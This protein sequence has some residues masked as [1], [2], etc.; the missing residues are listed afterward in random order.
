MNN[1]KFIK[2]LSIGNKIVA[3]VLFVSVTV[4]SAGFGFIA[5]WDINRLKNE[6]QSKLILDAKLI[7]DYCVV[8]L[9]FEDKR[10]AREALSRLKLVESV[11]EGF[12][13]DGA[14]SLFAVYP[15]TLKPAS[16]PETLNHEG[17]AFKDG[18][19]YINEPV[20]FQGM[21]LGKLVVQANSKSLESRKRNLALTIMGLLSILILISYLLAVRMQKIISSPIVEL[22]NHFDRIAATKDY[23]AR[24]RRRHN[25]ETGN[26]YDG[27]NELLGTIDAQNRERKKLIDDLSHSRSML[28]TILD[29]IPQSIFWK[30]KNSVYLGCNR[31]FADSAGIG[32]PDLIA[33]KTDQDLPWK[34]EAERYRADD[35]EVMTNGTARYHII[36]PLFRADGKEIWA[37]T[38]KIPLTGSDGRVN[39]VLGVLEDITDRKRAEEEL[40]QSEQR[41]K[42]LL[43][44]ITDYTYSV[45]IQNERPVKTVHGTGCVKVTGFKPADYTAEDKL[46]LQ[47]V[48]PDDRK[49]VEHYADP[50]YGG[51]EIPPLEHR[52]IHKNGPVIWVRNT[53]VLKHD[54]NGK[55]IGYDGL[56]SDITGR[57]LAEEEIR[58]LNAE[59]EDR[60]TQRTAQLETAN[61]ELEAF[62]YSVSHDLRAP[63]RHASGYVDLLLKRFKSDLPEKGRHYLNSI[64]DSVHQMGMLIDDL[65]QFSR[66][67]RT[68]MRQAQTDM[69]GIVHE[70]MES[71][72]QDNPLRA[73]EWIAG[74]LPSVFCDEAML[75]LVW[76]NLLSN[77][78]K[79]TRTREKATIEIGAH[80]EDKEFV[81][82]ARDNGVGFDMRYAQKLFGVFQRLH[83]MEEFEGTGIGLANVRR[84][85]S[86]HEGRTWAQAEPDKGATLY[87]SLPKFKKE[88]P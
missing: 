25:D 30:D 18:H 81:F 88:T 34:R 39:A 11:D 22:K 26:L 10:Q 50:L 59:L 14:G 56:I 75:K 38:A 62:S 12:L 78:V 86:R 67:G 80:E 45:E 4:I 52:I 84:I 42:Q 32:H 44:S 48:H 55:V 64:A 16:V 23:S 87:F 79:F 13:F 85:I 74:R 61:K 49:T 40:R 1:L 19:F 82:F 77:A 33:G 2:D 36:E 70:V 41:Y 83:S 29:T 54:A 5:T 6:I 65:L 68:E 72:R 73:I 66:T 76:M 28:N 31:T 17:A 20:Y 3:I 8:P 24:V 53:Y 9:T 57:K 7:G 69:N 47:M 60:V 51:K 58:R 37:D 21:M 43:E 63:L 35:H 27:F 15:D 46:W 71:L